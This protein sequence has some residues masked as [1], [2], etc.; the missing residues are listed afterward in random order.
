MRLMSVFMAY[1]ATIPAANWMIQNVGQCHDGGPC[2][3]PLGFGLYAPSGVLMV[4]LALALRDAVQE[5]GGIKLA[6]AAIGMECILSA[7]IAPPALILASAA[8]FLLSETLDLAVYTP[9]RRRSL[10]MAIF[11]SGI[12]GSVIDSAAFLLIA[13]GSLQFMAG[14]IVGKLEITMAAA[15]VAALFAKGPLPAPPTQK[16]AA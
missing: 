12:V 1:V 16:G 6:A 5:I 10:S 9:L 15:I 11:A 8:A 13:F 3:I 14:Q 7:L 2:V 4:G